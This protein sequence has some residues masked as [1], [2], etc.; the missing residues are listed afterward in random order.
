MK[1]Y[2]L[3]SILIL[4]L[5]ISTACTTSLSENIS[6]ENIIEN[7]TIMDPITESEYVELA[8]D[9]SAIHIDD[10]NE[11][12]DN[13]EN[14][15]LYLG[16]KTCPYCRMFAPKLHT[17]MENNCSDLYYLDVENEDQHAEIKVFLIANNIQYV[18]SL[19][20]FDNDGTVETLDIDSQNIT[21]EEIYTFLD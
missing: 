18:P 7:E 14:F 21:V 12:I 8:E 16:R 1:K 20:T 17:A 10:I 5:S 15:N 11:K 9:F 6:E 4:F 19:L 13:E 2:R 3:L